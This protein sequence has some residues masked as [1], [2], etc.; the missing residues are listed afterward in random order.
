MAHR[1]ELECGRLI[2][3]HMGDDMLNQLEDIDADLAEDGKTIV[4]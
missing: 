2:L 1:E 3:T 4:L